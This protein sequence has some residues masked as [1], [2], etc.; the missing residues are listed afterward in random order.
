MPL[1][2]FCPYLENYHRPRRMHR[3]RSGS[4][5]STVVALLQCLYES[6]KGWIRFDD[7]DVSEVDVQCLRKGLGVVSQSPQLFE[8]ARVEDKYSLWNANRCTRQ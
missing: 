5:K 4:G 6:L 2:P 7:V 8:D 1:G 3:A